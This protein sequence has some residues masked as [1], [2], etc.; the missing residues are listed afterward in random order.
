VGVDIDYTKDHGRGQSTIGAFKGAIYDA[1]GLKDVQLEKVEGD[2][3]V[4]SCDPVQTEY[5]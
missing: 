5:F 2:G 4:R 1:M 3:D